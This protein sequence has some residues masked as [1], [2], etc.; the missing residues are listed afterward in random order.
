MADV[1]DHAVRFSPKGGCASAIVG[2]VDG[3]RSVVQVMAYTFTSPEIAQSLV[4]AVKRGLKV[5]VILDYA[6]ANGKYSVA[7]FLAS[8][9]VHVLLDHKHPIAHNKVMLL[10][11]R[12][13]I[14]GSFNYT[15]AAD[16]SNAENLLIVRS[17]PILTRQYGA[18]FDRHFA[19]STLYKGRK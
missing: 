11:Q 14:T 9:G 3:A 6:I 17:Y 7:D 2:E 10:D 4:R 8:Q 5:F 18:D 19:H 13:V 16:D 12:T 1:V 15:R